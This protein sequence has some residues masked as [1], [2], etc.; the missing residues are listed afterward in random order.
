[1][2]QLEFTGVYD[3]SGEGESVVI[4]LLLHWGANWV[5]VAAT[6]DTGASFCIFG[7]EIAE[8]PRSRFDQWCPQAFPDRK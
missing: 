8:G 5:P 7:T 6:V 1:M 2:Y 4:P 3:Y